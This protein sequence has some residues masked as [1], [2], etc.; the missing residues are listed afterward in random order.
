MT[1]PVSVSGFPRHANLGDFEFDVV[2][3]LD[4]PGTCYYS[5]YD[6]G[7]SRPTVADV[8]AGSDGDGN[9]AVAFGSVAVTVP[10]SVEN[11]GPGFVGNATVDSNLAAVSVYVIWTVC[12]DDE[13]VPNT[14]AS[15][16][17][18]SATTLP[19]ETPPVFLHSFPAVIDAAT[20]DFAAAFQTQ[21]D[22]PGLLFWSIAPRNE[23]HAASSVTPLAVIA[24]M[25]G[26]AAV[27]GSTV[28]ANGSVT[29]K[30]AITTGLE[31]ATTY[32]VW[33]VAQVRTVCCC[34]FG[35]SMRHVAHSA[36]VFVCVCVC[37][38]VRASACDRALMHDTCCTFL[39]WNSMHR[40]RM[41][42]R[43]PTFSVLS[44]A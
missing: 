29:T 27:S 12:A 17:K 26:V 21:L 4:E 8:R 18:I 16:V 39:E 25:P 10:L 36:R 43:H 2:V 37:V 3:A 6:S 33:C 11:G 19:D 7:A 42:S 28:I 20:E 44:P 24:G 9:A 34:C 38:C 14:Q 35:A 1:P 40:N 30:Q 13:P 5:V 23:S 31:A 15:G 22:E 41:T 32:D